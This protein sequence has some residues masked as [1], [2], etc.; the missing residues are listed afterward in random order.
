MEFY[1]KKM[2]NIYILCVT[3]IFAKKLQANREYY[4]K[5]I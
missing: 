1:W 4:F 3:D 5:N 2:R